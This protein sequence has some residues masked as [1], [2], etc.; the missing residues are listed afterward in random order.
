M[1]EIAGKVAVVTGAGS[2]IG[3]GMARALAGAGMHV[4]VADVELQAAEAVAQ[5]LN[6]TPLRVDVSKPDEVDA[7][8]SQVYEK[9]GAVHVLCNN[10]G[11][12]V[13][14]P[15]S[16]MTHDDWRWVVSVN[17]LGVAHC[18]T[19]FVPRMLKQEGEAHIVNTAS[20]MGLM[21]VPNLG[22]YS[23]TKAAVVGMSESLRSELENDQIGVTV[24]CPGSVRT[25]ITEAARNRP[26]S[27]KQTN[28]TPPASFSD[29][30]G[31]LDPD[32]LGLQVRDAIIANKFY[33][34][35]MSEDNIRD[36]GPL[37]KRRFDAV[38]KE[39]P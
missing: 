17:V 35:P 31:A 29:P 21:A 8:A 12:G 18:L 27:L 14:G 7:F 1:K 28:V 34:I 36:F 9:L 39:I 4:V 15:L 25:R 38:L 30:V 26:A 10:A 37:V 16:I 11:V 3:R 22:V 32:L 13:T 23:A 19:A 20:L 24:I 5:E 2:G 33:L 6:G